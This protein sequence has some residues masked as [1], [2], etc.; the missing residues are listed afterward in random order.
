MKNRDATLKR[1]EDLRAEQQG[2]VGDFG[3][4]QAIAPTRDEEAREKQA[5]DI[6]GQI[7]Q[8]QKMLEDAEAAPSGQTWV[9][10]TKRRSGFAPGSLARTTAWRRHTPT[11][12]RPFSVCRKSRSNRNPLSS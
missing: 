9:R 7:Q 1:I 6:Q 10:V 8:L 5:S 2:L 4:L 12:R 3:I 11:S